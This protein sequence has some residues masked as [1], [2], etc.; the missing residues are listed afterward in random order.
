MLCKIN[1]QSSFLK[2]EFS[3]KFALKF[4]LSDK[5]DEFHWYL[6]GLIDIRS[7]KRKHLKCADGTLTTVAN[8]TPAMRY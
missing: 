8:V 4:N 7:L 2:Q 1:R 5:C 3:N 6:D